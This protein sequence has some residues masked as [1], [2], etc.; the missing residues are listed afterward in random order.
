MGGQEGAGVKWALDNE[1]LTSLHSLCFHHHHQSLESQGGGVLL[2]IMAA[3]QDLSVGGGSSL[4]RWG[5]H[6]LQVSTRS[7]ICNVLGTIKPN[8]SFP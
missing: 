6:A 1:T 3:A 5:T 2:R 8:V 4:G 7:T